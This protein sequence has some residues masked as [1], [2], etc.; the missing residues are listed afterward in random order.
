[1]QIATIQ[2]FEGV[3]EFWIFNVFIILKQYAILIELQI[4][5]GNFRE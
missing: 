4:S 1:M 3:E 2:N 5:R